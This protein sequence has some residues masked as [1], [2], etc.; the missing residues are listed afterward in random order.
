M[1][2]AVLPPQKQHITPQQDICFEG[3]T[4]QNLTRKNVNALLNAIELLQ[5]T[6]PGFEKHTPGTLCNT[7]TFGTVGLPAIHGKECGIP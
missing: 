4:S 7:N 3:I 1:R 2:C 5:S 6:T